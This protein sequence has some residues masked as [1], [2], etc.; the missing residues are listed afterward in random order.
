M[1][2][3][4]HCTYVKREIR[5]LSEEDRETFLDAMHVM[6]QVGTKKGRQT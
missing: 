5:S 4:A 2:T 3:R 1:K 6:W